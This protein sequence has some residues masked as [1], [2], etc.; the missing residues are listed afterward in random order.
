[1]SR[2]CSIR[3]QVT[4]TVLLTLGIL[5]CDPPS[6]VRPFRI[7]PQRPVEQ[8][9]IE[10]LAAVPP[11]E[12]G[13]KR[14]PELVD[15]S[16]LDPGL[17]FDIRYAGRNNFMGTAFY[18]QA[19]AYLQ[20]PTAEALMAAHMELQQQ[21]FGLTIFDAY[22]P[23]LCLLFIHPRALNLISLRSAGAMPA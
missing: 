12:E 2:L 14:R 13:E 4:S 3:F 8:L 7:Q 20:R 23:W 11:V 9:E 6:E 21:G 22:R 10:A 18:R 1:M 15:L 17:R 16:L 5:G 19:K